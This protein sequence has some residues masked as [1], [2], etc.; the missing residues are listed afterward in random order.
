MK[1]AKEGGAAAVDRVFAI[2]AVF[3]KGASQ[4]TLAEI[5]SRTGFYKST[6]LRLIISLKKAA[7]VRK[8][9]E[10]RY[11]IGPEPLRFSSLY[12]A[13]F[14]LRDV[15]LPHL[16]HLSSVSGETSSFYIIDNDWR[17]ILYRV[18][19]RRTCFNPRR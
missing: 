1:S 18:E 2:L 3:D 9:A 11:C 4:R 17:V 5:A 8:T 7:F 15:L 14:R 13:S 16:E 6:I 12:Q 19:P 10:G